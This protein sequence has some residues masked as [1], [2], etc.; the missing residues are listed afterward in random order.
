MSKAKYTEEEIQWAI[1]KLMEKNLKQATREGAIELLDTRQEFFS[2]P[3]KKIEEDEKSGKLQRVKSS[4][5][6]N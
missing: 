6:K 2:L 4:Q 1:E 5:T 3:K